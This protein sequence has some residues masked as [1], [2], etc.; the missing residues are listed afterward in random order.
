MF[1]FLVLVLRLRKVVKIDHE[2]GFLSP[3]LV[4]TVWF[5]CISLLWLLVARLVRSFEVWEVCICGL[6]GASDPKIAVSV[7]IEDD[8]DDD[9]R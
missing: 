6:G 1:A 5:D 7:R 4:I 9:W 3:F 8:D 2:N